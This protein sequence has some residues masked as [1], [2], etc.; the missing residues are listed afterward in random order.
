M[1]VFMTNLPFNHYENPYVAQHLK[2]L[3]LGYEGPNRQTVSGTLLND[4]CGAVRKQVE[5]RLQGTRWLNFYTDKS[6][7]INK[8]T[9]INFLAHVPRGCGIDGV[10]YINSEINGAKTMDGNT[11]LAYVLAQ[12]NIATD[13]RLYRIHLY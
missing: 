4:C 2:G 10:F 12:A 11:Q 1:A 7:T 6:A 9:V 3:Q 5:A 13:G 8:D